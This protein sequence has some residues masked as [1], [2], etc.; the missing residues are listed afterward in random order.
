VLE[1]ESSLALGVGDKSLSVV[2]QESVSSALRL[3]VVV[4]V[5]FMIMELGPACEDA[6]ACR[7]TGRAHRKAAKVIVEVVKRKEDLPQRVIVKKNSEVHHCSL[8]GEWSCL[9]DRTR[10]KAASLPFNER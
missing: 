4:K 1:A 5:L 2:A 8:L 3:A 10:S 7:S 9:T 6:T